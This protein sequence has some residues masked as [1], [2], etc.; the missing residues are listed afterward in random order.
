MV[1]I[2]S[3]SLEVWAAF[4]VTSHHEFIDGIYRRWFNT[5]SHDD[6]S[7]FDCI[8]TYPNTVSKSSRLFAL[9]LLRRSEL[10]FPGA[11]EEKSHNENLQASHTDH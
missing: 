9:C 3:C 8:H 7:I 11:L 5:S 4:G 10:T 2:H 1:V 6:T